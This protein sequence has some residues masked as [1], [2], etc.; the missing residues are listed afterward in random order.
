[1]DST[2][3]RIWVLWYH[4]PEERS[5]APASYIKIAEITTIQQFWSIIDRVPKEAWECGMYFFMRQGFL[6]IWEAPEHEA[7]G[8]WSKKIEATQAHTA[9]IDMMVHCIA[10]EMMVHKK[11]TLAGISISPKGQFHIIKIWNTTTSVFEK[12]NLNQKLTYFKITD[13]V[14]YTAHKVRP[15]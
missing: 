1:M 11:D 4:D 2:L 3:S 6:P 15:K 14:T 8:S 5:Y 7:G 12:F 13:D 9:F 10:N